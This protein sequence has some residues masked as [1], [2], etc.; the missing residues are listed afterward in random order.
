RQC[1]GRNCPL[2]RVSGGRMNRPRN[3]FRGFSKALAACAIALLAAAALSAPAHAQGGGAG[4]GGSQG[5]N[6]AGALSVERP[7]LATQL[8]GLS[9]LATSSAISGHVGARLAGAP[10]F[11]IGS[12]TSPAFAYAEP[13]ANDRDGLAAFAAVTSTPKWSIWSNLNA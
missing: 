1:D 7:Y 2:P 3:V 5:Q 6:E 9:A 13:A 11:A 10:P 8:Q 12:L 4:K